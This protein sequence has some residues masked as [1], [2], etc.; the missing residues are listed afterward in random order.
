MRDLTKR[1]KGT[2]FHPQ[3]ADWTRGR[4]QYVQDAEAIAR[5]DVWRSRGVSLMLSTEDEARAIR[6]GRNG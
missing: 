3:D 1:K 5:K 2:G 4:E 6:E